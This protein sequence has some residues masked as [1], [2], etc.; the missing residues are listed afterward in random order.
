LA[1]VILSKM[2]FESVVKDLLLVRRF[3]VEVYCSKSKGSNDWSMMYKVRT[4]CCLVIYIISYGTILKILD[5]NMLS[6][7]V[8]HVMCLL[9][10]LV[11]KNCYKEHFFY[12]GPL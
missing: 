2:N 7:A 8:C 6:R 11:R 5:L 3:R 12:P 1:Y 4:Y 9:S 10:V